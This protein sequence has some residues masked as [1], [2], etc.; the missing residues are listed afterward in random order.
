MRLLSPVPLA[1]LASTASAQL[2]NFE[3]QPNTWNSSLSL[4][5]QHIQDALL[6]DEIAKSVA[7]VTN[8]DRSQLAYGGPSEDEFYT[9]PL[10]TNSTG[11]LQPG[12]VLKTQLVTDTS[13]FSIPPNTALSR[14]MYTTT[15]FN[16]TVVP[17]TAFVLWPFE[18]RHFGHTN[19]SRVAAPTVLWTHGT[20]GFHSDAA[21]SAMRHLWYGFSAPFTLAQDGY[22]VVGP[23]YAGLGIDKSW[24]GSHIA[25]QWDVAQVGARDALHALQAAWNAFPGKL[26]KEFVSMGHSQGGGVAWGVA[27]RLALSVDE[28]PDKTFGGY[29]GAVAVSPVVDVFGVSPA[30]ISNFV[31]IAMSS[32]FPDFTLDLWLTPLGMAR[33]KLWTSIKGGVGAA[34]QLFLAA[35]VT[36]ENYIEQSWHGAAFEKLANPGRKDFKGPLLVLQGTEDIYVPFDGVK[37]A[38]EDTCG[39][40]PE[41]DLDFLIVNGT[42]HVPTLD[43]T[44]PR[45]LRWIQDR[46]EGKP[47]RQTGCSTSHLKSWLPHAQY[48][49]VGGSVIQW[50]ADPKFSYQAIL[51]P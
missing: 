41:H 12:V 46:F 34:Q 44:R 51:G 37:S 8:S 36:R 35:E 23:D 33:N 14:F 25:H 9:L 39:L 50:V 13:G 16:G 38:V 4:S 20:S 26:T 47:V 30:F 15:T 42:G 31:G 49:A 48:L 10:L 40:F 19:S 5:T 32:I 2:G 22:A 29:K 24:D 43:A 11:P 45:W 27:E 7:V 6:T 18:P 3:V 28:F 21:P 17:A 1:L